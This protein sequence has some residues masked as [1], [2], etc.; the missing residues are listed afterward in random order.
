MVRQAWQCIDSKTS[1]RLEMGERVGATM[2]QSLYEY[3]VFCPLGEE[4]INTGEYSSRQRWKTAAEKFAAARLAGQAMPIIFG[5]AAND[6]GYLFKWAIVDNLTV[7]DDGTTIR[8]SSIRELSGH[9]SRDLH[10]ESNG[11]GVDRNVRRGAIVVRTPDFLTSPSVDAAAKPTMKSKVPKREATASRVFIAN[12]G[13]GNA[14]WP[15]CYE[16]PSVA[17]FED[18]DTWPYWLAQDRA[19]F[20]EHCIKTKKTATGITPTAP[21]ASRSFDLGDI[22]S[23]TENDI[24]IHREKDELWWTTSRPGDAEHSRRPAFNP[25]PLVKDIYVLHKPADAWSNKTKRGSPLRWDAL[26]P[27]AKE[28]LFTEGT[29]QQLQ[30][31]NA[32]YAI[33]LIEGQS[34]AP[35][36]SK[37]LWKEKEAISKKGPVKIFSARERAITMMAKTALETVANANGQQVLRTVKNKENRFGSQRALEEYIDKLVTSQEGLCAV[38][39]LPLQYPGEASDLQ[40]LCSLDRID[41]NG[42]YEEGNLQ[43]VCR[44]INHWK[45]DEND[46][47]FRRL[48]DVVRN[49]RGDLG[50][51]E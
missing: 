16:R 37:P 44:F 18:E 5:D 43:I 21:V 45:S 47:E 6:S 19:G 33:A 15:D 39:G 12:F 38:T 49:S 41:S 31:D 34:L 28:F 40:M 17:T 23:E 29:L 48:I 27:K 30:P 3:A 11:G 20:I 24:W 32:E 35:W 46:A 2:V 9:D 4:R 25:T 22:I 14:L 1:N 50:I 42:H 51:R 10:K 7:D 36:H 8:F 26:H 13:P